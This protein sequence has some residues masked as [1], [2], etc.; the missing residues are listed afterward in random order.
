M[1]PERRILHRP[2]TFSS[3]CRG[4]RRGRHQEGSEVKNL[5]KAA[6]VAMAAGVILAAGAGIEYVSC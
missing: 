5:K 6:A 4:D 3:A 1:S 2:S